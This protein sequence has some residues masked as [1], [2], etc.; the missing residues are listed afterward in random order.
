[1][2]P[3]AA[4]GARPVLDAAGIDGALLRMAREIGARNTPA[5]G[6][7]LIGIRTRG[8]P[9]AMRLAT[10]L[11]N[12]SG[13]EVPVG[14]IDI[15]LYRD[16]FKAR[17]G[18]PVQATHI[19]CPLDARH[20]V[21]VDDVLF[22]GRTIRAAMDGLTDF[23]RPRSIQLA[24][25]VDRGHREFPIQADFVGASLETAHGEQV[26]VQVSEIDGQDAATLLEPASREA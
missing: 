20:V 19:P 3:P 9:L 6:L 23:G 17:Q 2:K 15:T 7:V 25:L 26:R 1:M 12:E 22:T 8:V 13:V 4:D 11:Q 14:T 18:R 21:L 10:L 24:V 16:D 5:T